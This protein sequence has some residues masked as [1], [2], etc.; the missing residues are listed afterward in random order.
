MIELVHY[1]QRLGVPEPGVRSS[2][3]SS[4]RQEE[5]S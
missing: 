4:V 2:V 5:S 1:T 3:V